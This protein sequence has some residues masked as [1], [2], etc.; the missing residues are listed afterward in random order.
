VNIIEV[1]DQQCFIWDNKFSYPFYKWTADKLIINNCIDHIIHTYKFKK[2]VVKDTG[3]SGCYWCGYISEKIK[4]YSDPVYKN[5][6]CP[7]CFHMKLWL[8]YCR[9]CGQKFSSMIHLKHHYSLHPKHRYGKINCACK[10]CGEIFLSK[11]A[12]F[13]HLNIYK[14]HQV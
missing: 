13:K 11:S 4:Y 10:V 12:L 1:A 7:D 2:I 3:R 14:S 9:E 5:M 6:Y 8:G